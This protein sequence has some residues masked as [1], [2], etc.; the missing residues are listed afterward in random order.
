M[1]NRTSNMDHLIKV[2]LKEIWVHQR[3][4]KTSDNELTQRY[5]LG[6]VQAKKEVLQALGGITMVEFLDD[7]WTP[8]ITD[9]QD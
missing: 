6:M 8:K 2:L 1:E 5:F 7:G 3:E 9:F 4:I